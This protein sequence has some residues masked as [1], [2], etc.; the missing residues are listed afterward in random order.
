MSL[1]SLVILGIVCFVL[2]LIVK[3]PANLALSLFAPDGVEFSGVEGSLWNGSANALVLSGS[4]VGSITWDLKLLRLLTLKLAADVELERP[5][6]GFA[7]GLV[8][9]GLGNNVQLTNFRALINSAVLQIPALSF[10]NADLAFDLQE[11]NLKSGWPTELNG[12]VN[13]ANLRSNQVNAMLGNFSIAFPEQYDSPLVGQF[14]DEQATLQAN[15]TLTLEADRG[16]SVQ[17]TIT[18][19]NET[20]SSVRNALRF[21]GAPG[22]NGA[23]T[24]NTQGSL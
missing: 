8:A 6:N 22:A 10:V 13:I 24:L 23:V 7:Q 9:V 15:G 5:D 20:D 19:T 16:Y 18:P 14:T 12:T 11:A 2:F 3:L 21:M 1:K 4:N 17:G